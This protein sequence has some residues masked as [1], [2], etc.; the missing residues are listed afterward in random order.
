MST[1]FKQKTHNH[2]YEKACQIAQELADE[3]AN[4][5]DL[6]CRW[7]GNELHFSRSGADGVITVG[8]DEVEISVK[9]G[10]FLMALKPTVESEIDNYMQTHF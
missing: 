9:L 6:S 2:G 7:E 5:Y 10:F 8:E 4:K 1:I 3:L